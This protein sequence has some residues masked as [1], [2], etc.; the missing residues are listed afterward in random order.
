MLHICFSEGEYCLIEHAGEVIGTGSALREWFI[1]WRIKELEAMG[2]VEIEY[3]D[4]RFILNYIRKLKY[5]EEV[6]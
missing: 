3:G 4:H 2:Y 5:Y 1:N 6:N